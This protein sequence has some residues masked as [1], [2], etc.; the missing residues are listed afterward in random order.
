[1]KNTVVL[2]ITIC[3]ASV[4]VN[5]Q[6]AAVR[7]PAE[8]KSFV[9]KGTKA[10]AVESADLNG[11][12]LKDYILVLEK[13]NSK[14]DADDFPENQ[15]PLLILVRGKDKKLSEAARNENM[16]MC[17]RCGG[18][19]GDPFESVTV[20]KN[21]FTVNHYGGS[22]WRWTANYRFNYSRTDKTWQLVKIEKT[23]FSTNAPN[24][25]ERTVMTPPKN[26]GKVDIADF[27]P[28]DY[29]ETEETASGN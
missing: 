2:I 7:V 10:I 16:V 28:T 22:N 19:W 23:S 5:A 11:D 17:S 15:R 24:K 20:A 25:V 29:E 21:T 18:V 9:E 26:F 12:G 6:T 1:M 3:F 14:M 4:F 13:K 27:N 8:V